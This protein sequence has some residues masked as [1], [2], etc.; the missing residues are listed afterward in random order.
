MSQNQRIYHHFYLHACHS[1]SNLVVFLSEMNI[2]N[3]L[4]QYISSA[5]VAA[6]LALLQIFAQTQTFFKLACV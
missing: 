6:S 5:L 1:N 2:V 4:R 3:D